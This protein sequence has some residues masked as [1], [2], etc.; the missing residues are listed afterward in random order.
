MNYWL[1]SFVIPDV[2]CLSFY[3]IDIV[4]GELLTLRYA[5]IPSQ[6]PP[7]SQL[8][9][10]L[11]PF[12]PIRLAISIAWLS[13]LFPVFSLFGLCKDSLFTFPSVPP[14]GICF[15]PTL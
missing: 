8:Q 7:E 4:R 15:R 3:C 2:C 13:H 1:L 11:L 12:P 6:V 14:F 5:P 9:T 10:F